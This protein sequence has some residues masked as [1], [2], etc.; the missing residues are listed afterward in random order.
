VIEPSLS[1]GQHDRLI[2]IY[3]TWLDQDDLG[4]R[5]LGTESDPRDVGATSVRH[6]LAELLRSPS[7]PNADIRRPAA[8][9]HPDS[10]LLQLLGSP[11]ATRAGARGLVEAVARHALCLQAIPRLLI[12]AAGS[13]N[14]AEE[15]QPTSRITDPAARTALADTLLAVLKSRLGQ[16][17]I[18]SFFTVDVASNGY[19]LWDAHCRAQ[20][21]EGRP[22]RKRQC[23]PTSG[24][25]SC[26]RAQAA[27]C[28][29]R[30]RMAW[31]IASSGP[32]G[33]Q[34]EG[35]GIS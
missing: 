7:G 17:T 20:Q 6:F 9:E 35:L 21:A 15:G 16:R 11:L 31:R 33:C 29:T 2:A 14:L 24:A 23:A 12:E 30:W 28:R 34:T 19:R 32:T 10:T 25:P 18:R 5:Y 13:G 4:Q 27:S 8:L 22:T 26:V 1:G 3:A